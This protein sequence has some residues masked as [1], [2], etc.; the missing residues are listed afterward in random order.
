MFSSICPY[1]GLYQV[2]PLRTRV[3]LAAMVMKGD[4]TSSKLRHYW[5]LTI[6]MFSVISMTF[7]GE[8]Y[9]SAKIQSVYSAATTDWATGHYLEGSYPSVEML[10][11]YSPAPADWATGHSLRE[12]YPAAE[13]Q[14]VYSTALANWATGNTLGK[15]Y[16]SAEMQSV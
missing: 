11:L 12:S 3:D 1:I 2:L 5:N 8:F 4:S 6:G 10:L 13:M 9:P 14:S 15:S 16:P 7:V